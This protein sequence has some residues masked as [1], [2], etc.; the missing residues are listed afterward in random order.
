MIVTARKLANAGPTRPRQADLKRSVSTAYYALFHTLAKDAADM[1][2]GVG[3]NRPDK[4]WR[5]VY[6]S[7]QH[8]EAKAACRLLG[9]NNPGFPQP[10]VDCANTF[11]ILQEER[12]SADYA[13]DFRATRADALD[14]IA[15]AEQAIANL[16]AAPKKD[17]RA[18]AVLLLFKKRP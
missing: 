16:F 14:A 17:R 6:R 11:V 15:R 13:S 9:N 1:L 4:A 10:L 18:F 12:H 7:L 2:V 8:G 3:S 5:Q